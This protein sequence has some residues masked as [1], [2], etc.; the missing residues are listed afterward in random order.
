MTRAAQTD[1]LRHKAGR[2][3]KD[4]CGRSREPS[5]AKPDESYSSPFAIQTFEAQAPATRC[6]RRRAKVATH[7][8]RRSS[9]PC[10][11]KQPSSGN[12]AVYTRSARRGG[13]GSE[14]CGILPDHAQ[15][16][17]KRTEVNTWV[18]TCKPLTNQGTTLRRRCVY[19][20]RGARLTHSQTATPENQYSSTAQD[21]R[22]GENE[23]MDDPDEK[24]PEERT[25]SG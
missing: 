13:E 19:G 9:R 20:A 10:R 16:V 18:S 4:H 17:K 11:V 7:A 6:S 2:G 23:Q 22:L 24:K 21:S 25:H 15:H 1:D 5:R 8:A 3:R 14:W 12:N